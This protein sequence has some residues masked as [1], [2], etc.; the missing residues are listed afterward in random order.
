MKKNRIILASTDDR[1][2][3]TSLQAW[4]IVS[5]HR[6]RTGAFATALE[7]FLQLINVLLQGI[8]PLLQLLLAGVLNLAH[9]LAA[10]VHHFGVGQSPGF[11]RLS[12]QL[13]TARASCSSSSSIRLK[14]RR[15]PS[16]AWMPIVSRSEASSSGLERC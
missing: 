14:P 12:H 1:G 9:L 7:R 5:S 13:C 15:T 10:A 3:I 8:Y 6:L 4:Q 2:A 11:H 16:A